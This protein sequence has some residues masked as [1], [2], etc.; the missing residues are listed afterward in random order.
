MNHKKNIA[1]AILVLLLV[2]TKI[3]TVHTATNFSPTVKNTQT[4]TLNPL[5]NNIHSNSSLSVKKIVTEIKEGHNINTDIP[6]RHKNTH[7]IKKLMHI[8]SGI[9]PDN[10]TIFVVSHGYPPG[11][12]SAFFE[13]IS[14]GNGILTA[15]K[16]IRDN[17]IN[18]TCITF[19]YNDI[20][21]I[22][23][24][25]QT[26]DTACLET[27][28]SN[29]LQYNPKAKLVLIGECRGAK[30]ILQYIAQNPKISENIKAVILE[31]PMISVK[32]MIYHVFSH[33]THWLPGSSAT[34]YFIFKCFYPNYNEKN[35]DILPYLE[36]LP[37]NLP[38][39]IGHTKND[40]LIPFD[41]ITILI[42]GLKNNNVGHIY[43]LLLDN[44]KH[45]MLTL[46][47]EF[48]QAVNAF[49]HKYNLP[50]NET[51]AQAGTELLEHFRVS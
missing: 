1:M 16:Y 36:H 30:T 17:I 35:D 39:F 14:K 41:N 10:E 8:T 3:L 7:E 33:Y 27:V 50:C 5:N 51:L 46:T 37:K 44:A 22:S 28:C 31:S 43:F 26:I 23:N 20:R 9:N 13:K 29:I 12:K 24:W 40:P 15:Y 34:A 11:L 47:E 45:S 18:G 48:Q 19:D 21:K 49:L 42:N 32:D 2:A 38:I 4:I 25:G 6:I